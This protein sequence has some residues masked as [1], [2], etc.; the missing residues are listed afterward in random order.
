MISAREALERLRE[1]SRHGAEILERRIGDEGRLIVGAEYSLES[2]EVD[3]FAGLPPDAG[4]GR[5]GAP[6]RRR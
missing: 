1:G 3:F 6:R 4:R 5:R 2:G